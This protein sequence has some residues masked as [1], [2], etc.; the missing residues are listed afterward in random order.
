[1]HGILGQDRAIGILRHALRSGRFHHAWIF[2]GPKGVGKFTT[3]LGIART[4]L[5]PEAT[6]NLAGEI[7]SDPAS[8]SNR[9]IDAGTHPDL[10]VIRKELAL[11][12]DDRQLRERKLLTIPLDL[13][14]ERVIGGKVGEAQHEAPAYRTAL[15]GHGKAFIIDEA[16]LLAREA[17]NA[18]LKTL[19]EPPSQTWFFLIT[20]QP[21]RLLPTIHSRCQHVRFARLDDK[22]MREWLK[23]AG[24]NA[25]ADAAT[26]SW[27]TR[28]A[29]GSPGVAAVALEY[30]FHH[31]QQTLDPL[32]QELEGGRFPVTMGDTLAALVSE[33][34]EAWVKKHGAKHTSKDAA[35]KDGARHLFTLLAAHLR[36]RLEQ[37]CEAEA[38]ASPVIAAIESLREAE[39]QLESN[40]NLKMLLEN[41]AAQWARRPA[42]VA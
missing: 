2:S 27:V 1:M 12:S 8:R 35:N 14:R 6:T 41:L 33:F 23:R 11:Y 40:V 7:E 42:G 19:E 29:E 13:L 38:D 17:Q 9:M 37:A 3:A 16:E 36:H 26:L 31:W 21:D 15:M 5:D 10:H 34:A 20:S 39:Q 22:S 24:S 18:M 30:G 4:L 28:F 32:F 25:S